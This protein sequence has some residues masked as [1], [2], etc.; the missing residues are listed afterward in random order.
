MR[1]N[2]TLLK[3]TLI[4]RLTFVIA[5]VVATRL[6]IKESR[7][8]EPEVFFDSHAYLA[9]AQHILGGRFADAANGFRG[10]SFPLLLAL[11]EVLP[12]SLTNVVAI[13]NALGAVLFVWAA[14]RLSPRFGIVGGLL[15]VALVTSRTTICFLDTVLS[16]TMVLGALMLVFATMLN[17]TAAI[18]AL[19][20]GT[21]TWPKLI[22]ASLLSTGATVFLYGLKSWF[23]LLPIG[24]MILLALSVLIDAAVA[25]SKPLLKV[26]GVLWMT[27]AAS[28]VGAAVIH[29]PS[30]TVSPVYQQLSISLFI[31]KADEYAARR[32]AE[33]P[34]DTEKGKLFTHYAAVLKDGMATCEK[35]QTIAMFCFDLDTSVSLIRD[36]YILDPSGLRE[37][38]RYSYKRFRE[39]TSNG[40][41][42]LAGYG[43]GFALQYGNR[44]PWGH[45]LFR[46][47]SPL[48]GY[49]LLALG[50]VCPLAWIRRLWRTPAAERTASQHVIVSF[51]SS[52][53]I[54]SFAFFCFLAIGAGYEK[55][56][57]ELPG[58]L[59]L[60]VSL[61]LWLAL[62]KSADN[63]GSVV[64]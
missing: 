21:G 61:I 31:L 48:L 47:L 7:P 41:S 4:Q 5:I 49:L 56:R 50:I 8:Y 58:I 54:A 18:V 36:V 6:I 15:A 12:G 29:H 20:R 51:L 34:P 46:T 37:L 1:F 19:H 22:L 39:N 64:S 55:A 24:G 16:E 38:W 30:P 26:A 17:M 63:Q 13:F 52:W 42:A 10:P 23:A 44:I 33:L 28:L 43:E 11:D 40:Q 60:W 53:T 62:N 35:A 2:L 45:D 32:A 3:K 27:I 57:I 9:S 14:Y 59:A 25:R